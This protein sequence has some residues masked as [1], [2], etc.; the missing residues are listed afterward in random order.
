[1]AA[2]LT[3]SCDAPPQLPG[4]QLGT[5]NVIGTLGT[6]T[7]GTGLGAPS[8]WDFTVQLS[9]DTTTSPTTFYWLPSV[10]SQLSNGMTSTTKVSISST[11][12]SNIG[13]SEATD[14]SAAVEGPCDL[15]QSTQLDLTLGLGSPPTTFTG[16][17]TY[18]FVT[19]TGVSTTSDCTDELTSS[20][21]QFDTLPCTTTYTLTAGHQ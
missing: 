20:G 1:M 11:V 16:S 17:L 15:Q 10:G 6:N 19:S 4:T 9:E 3:L 2:L 5:Y 13:G 8:P 21:G 12:T 18:T 7:C 14:A